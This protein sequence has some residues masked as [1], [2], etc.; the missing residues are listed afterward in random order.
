MEYQPKYKWK[1]TWPGEVGLNGKPLEDFEG[2]D[3]KTIIGRIRHEEAGPM[4]GKWQW[5]GQGPLRMKRHLPQQGYSASAR[6]ASRMAEE[7]YDT[8]LRNNRVVG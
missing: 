4:K 3:G 6:E 2:W 5:N 7:Y 8:L 1:Q